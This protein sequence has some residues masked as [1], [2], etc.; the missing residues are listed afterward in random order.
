MGLSSY[1]YLVNLVFQVVSYREDC[2]NLSPRDQTGEWLSHFA[3]RSLEFGV[4]VHVLQFM[5]QGWCLNWGR[6]S[7][8]GLMALPRRIPSAL[9]LKHQLSVMGCGVR[10]S[11]VNPKPSTL[12]PLNPQTI[13][14]PKPLDPKP[15]KTLDPKPLK[16][17]TLRCN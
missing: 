5:V 8:W 3:G 14:N 1:R 6:A 11:W 10:F 4:F 15:P 7:M 12:K 16:P 17:Q 9:S 13:S 2:L